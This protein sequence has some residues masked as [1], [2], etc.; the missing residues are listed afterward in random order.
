LK[1][2]VIYTLMFGQPQTLGDASL[3]FD[4]ESG[5]YLYMRVMFKNVMQPLK[6]KCDHDH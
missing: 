2:W 1:Y 4:T 5:C 3:K 6:L